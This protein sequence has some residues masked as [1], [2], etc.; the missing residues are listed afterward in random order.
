MTQRQAR[1]IKLM[2]ENVRKPMGKIMLESGYSA[3]TSRKPKRLTESKA[4]KEVMQDQ[5]LDEKLF[6]TLKQALVA[7]KFN[8]KA[9]IFE[10][11]HMA[12]LKSLEIAFRLRGIL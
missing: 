6:T 9:R 5:L 3:Q 12:R 2:S 10:P 4:F 11:D 1:A 7:T 8:P